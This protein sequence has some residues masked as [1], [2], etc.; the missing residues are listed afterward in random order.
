MVEKNLL[1]VGIFE[2]IEKSEGCPLC[3]LWLKSEEQHMDFLLTNEANMSS[4]VRN[5]VLTAKGFCNRHAHLLYKTAYK[6][7]TEDGLGYAIYMKDIIGIISEQLERLTKQSYSLEDL[8][9]NFLYWRKRKQPFLLLSDTV[10]DA[11]KGQKCPVCKYL[12]SMDAVHLRTLIQMLDVEDFQKQFK[13]SKGLCLPHFASAFQII[14]RN[15][16]KNPSSITKTLIETEKENFQMVEHYLLEFIR[17]Q[18]WDFREERWGPKADANHIAL[19]LL[20]GVEGLCL[21]DK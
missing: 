13:S 12:Q 21:N 15:K 17:K 19:N 20:V 18:S 10:K 3:Y 4:E 11:V 8:K 14:S 5:E 16:F 7:G 2:G 9:K 6:G 1:T